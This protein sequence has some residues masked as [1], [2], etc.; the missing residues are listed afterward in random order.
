[1]VNR[2]ANTPIAPAPSGEVRLACVGRL[3]PIKGVDFVIHSVARLRARGVSCR[4]RVIGDGTERQVLEQLAKRLGVDS[5]VLFTGTLGELDVQHALAESDVFVSGSHQEGFSLA[6]LEAL[7]QGLPAVVTDVGSARDVVRNGATGYVIDNRD[8][9][10]FA[11]RVL[12]AAQRAPAMKSRCIQAA[13]P[14]SS[15]AVSASIVATLRG[16]VENGSVR[17]HEPRKTT[18]SEALR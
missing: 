14:Y 8:P 4:L 17:L 2:V 6:L 3:E 15:E 18:L 11:D 10:M 12:E 13:E 9:D 1:M 5:D 7:A 16:M